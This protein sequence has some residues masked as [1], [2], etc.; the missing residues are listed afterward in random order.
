MVVWDLKDDIAFDKTIVD[1]KRLVGNSVF[2]I[3]IWKYTPNEN[4]R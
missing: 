2:G 1:F 4:S 3:Q